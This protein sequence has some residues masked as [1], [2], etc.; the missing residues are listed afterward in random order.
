[1][2]ALWIAFI[3]VPSNKKIGELNKQLAELRKKESQEIP[4]YVVE[5][6]ENLVDSL[7]AILSNEQQRFFE[8]K[9]LLELGRVMESIGREFGLKLV[10]IAPEYE[11]LS[12][13]TDETG[14]IFELPSIIR[15][16]GYFL[17]FAKFLDAIP[18]FPFIIKPLQV[19]IENIDPDRRKVL[20]ELKGI[21][22][23]HKEQKALIQGNSVIQ[24]Q[25]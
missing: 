12:M 17:Q 19:K 25:V 7:S 4:L 24:D 10:S 8:E 13:L 3:L 6:L 5:S 18:S 2:S 22:A 15:F 9:N 23:I 11:S 14:E 21:I 1:L 20:I 16:E